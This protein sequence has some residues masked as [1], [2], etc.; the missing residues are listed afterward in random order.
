MNNRLETKYKNRRLV[1]FGH[2]NKGLTSA[3]TIGDSADGD[4]NPR[5]WGSR[6]LTTLNHQN[7]LVFCCVC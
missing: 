3:P 6:D 1:F 4:N 2:D 7:N 5:K